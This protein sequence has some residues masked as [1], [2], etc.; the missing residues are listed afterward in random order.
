MNYVAC[1]FGRQIFYYIIKKNCFDRYI[2]KLFTI[3]IVYIKENHL[4]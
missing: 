1:A 2:M 3:Y 4:F